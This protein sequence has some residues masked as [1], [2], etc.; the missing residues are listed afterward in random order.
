MKNAR[1]RRESRE[2]VDI[3]MRAAR[4]A[5]LDIANHQIMMIYNDLNLEF[6]RNITMSTLTIIIQDFLQQ[7]NDRKNI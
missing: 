2:Y 4:S 6:Q 5:E 1:R 3:I 7:L